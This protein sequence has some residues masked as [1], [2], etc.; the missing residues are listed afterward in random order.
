MS[1]N[2]IGWFGV[3]KPLQLC[4][5]YRS[6]IQKMKQKR[7]NNCIFEKETNENR[8]KNF[9]SKRFD[10]KKLRDTFQLFKTFWLKYFII[11]RDHL[12]GYC[13]NIQRSN[14]HNAPRVVAHAYACLTR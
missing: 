3:T 13:I 14:S 8:L 7:E 2:V 12:V 1:Y 5:A 9:P 11:T 4:I 6:E 10:F